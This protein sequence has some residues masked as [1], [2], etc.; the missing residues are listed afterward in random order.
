MFVQN[1]KNLFI[2]SIF[3]KTVNSSVKTLQAPSPHSDVSFIN[4]HAFQSMYI[5][6]FLQKKID[7]TYILLLTSISCKKC[8]MSIA[9]DESWNFALKTVWKVKIYHYADL[10]IT[11]SL[12]R[13]LTQ[14]HINLNDF[15]LRFPGYHSLFW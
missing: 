1:L 15:G 14:H 3:E 11:D 6:Q 5:R 7:Y 9:G 2:L 8:Q 4:V 10:L 12:K 13:S